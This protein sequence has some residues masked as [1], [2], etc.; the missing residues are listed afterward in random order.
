MPATVY[1][2]MRAACRAV[3][4]HAQTQSSLNPEQTTRVVTQAQLTRQSSQE[5]RTQ[6]WQ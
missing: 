2:H 5:I 3:K 4:S 6:V 1:M